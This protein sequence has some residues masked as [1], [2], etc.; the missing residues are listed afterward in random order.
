MQKLCLAI[1]A[2]TLSMLS[3]AQQPTD[4][5]DAA[6]FNRILAAQET[7]NP[8]IGPILTSLAT[9]RSKSTAGFPESFLYTVVDGRVIID[10][11]ATDSVNDLA[12]ALSNLGLQDIATF[13]NMVS[14]A[15]PVEAIEDL[16]LL[17]ELA[18]AFP[19]TFQ[20]NAG[21]TTTRGDQSLASDLARMDFGVDG[22][23]ITIGVISD[24][25]DCLG[26][27]AD[28]VA[29]GDLPDNVLILEESCPGSDEGRGMAQI[30]HDIA[31]GAD[32][33][34]HTANGGQA[35]FASGILELAEAGCDI[36][37]DDILYLQETT[38]QDG[39]VAQAVDEVVADR[40]AYFS[41]VGNSGL[42]EAYESCWRGSG[43]TGPNGGE[44][45]DFDPGPGIDTAQRVQIPE[46]S[47][48]LQL[49][50]DDASFSV[51]G[52]PGADGD[53][54][55][56]ATSDNLIIVTSNMPNIGMDAQEYALIYNFGPPAEAEIMIELADGAPPSRI[57]YKT[58]SSFFALDIL[59]YATPTA[60]L[61]GHA[62]A[63]GAAAVGAA[64][65]YNTPFWNPLLSRASITDYSTRGGTDILVNKH[66]NPTF[67][68]RRQPRFT[69]PEGGN[70][71]FFG[72]DL[73]FPV[74][75]TNEPDGFPNFF[76]TSAS[77][78]HVA[79]VAA[80]VLDAYS[81][82]FP[83]GHRKRPKPQKIYRLLERTA[84]DMDDPLTPGFDVGFD[85]KTGHGFIDALAAIRRALGPFGSRA[86][87]D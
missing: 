4:R 23:G 43:I 57:R 70:T 12:A 64:A 38:F 3:I 55:L 36:I 26:G 9:H 53:L 73:D 42:D 8:K 56:S 48:T 75:G 39:I 51:S 24:S 47:T 34:F 35:N 60:T 86:A 11:V 83:H 17:P 37:V 5:I 80:L 31:P 40:V 72:T 15:L 1:G 20:T 54:A 84:R 67:K 79:A 63:K 85:H 44:L 71:T 76:G 82:R 2:L 78:P 22:S 19:S 29:S 77:A 87:D 61:F 49:V 81:R 58:L 13:G 65:W 14:G 74:A 33:V 6:T 7:A 68:F 50:W 45:H 52:A 16:S 32:I 10:A 18:L 62:N 66:G 28:D 59:E 27:A 25:F 41:S 21:L 69:G 46:G 30:I